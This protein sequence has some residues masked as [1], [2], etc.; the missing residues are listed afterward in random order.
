MKR[1]RQRCCAVVL[2]LGGFGLATAAAEAR[3]IRSTIHV[4]EVHSRTM[5][6]WLHYLSAGPGMWTR[7][8]HPQVSREIRMTIDHALASPDPL[9]NEF[10]NYLVWK[11]SLDPIRFTRYHPRLSPELARLSY[12]VVTSVPTPP[13]PEAQ[14]V[15]SPPTTPAP[16]TTITTTVP[17]I[18]SPPDSTGT[19]VPEPSPLVISLALI[20]SGVWWRWRATRHV[21]SGS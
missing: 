3:P 20:G 9:H 18:T 12:P 7:V 10:V 14:T 4:Q 2:A 16:P 19:Q 6:E 5:D 13:V 17:P 15:S 11:R 1:E 21:P 8:V